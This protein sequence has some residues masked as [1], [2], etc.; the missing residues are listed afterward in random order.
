MDSLVTPTLGPT[1][2]RKVCQAGLQGF[3]PATEPAFDPGWTL[4]AGSS[5]CTGTGALWVHSHASLPFPSAAHSFT[6]A[7]L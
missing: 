6:L 7:S 4:S 3:Q 5:A 1:V 2:G